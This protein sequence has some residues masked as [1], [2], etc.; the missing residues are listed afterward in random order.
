MYSQHTW[1]SGPK[2]FTGKSPSLK[3]CGG[4]GTGSYGTVTDEDLSRSITQDLHTRTSSEHSRRTFIQAPTQRIFKILLQGPLEE[5]FNRIFSQGPVPDHAPGPFQELLARDHA[6]ASGSI[7]LKILKS[8][9]YVRTRSFKAL[10]QDPLAGN[11][12]EN[13]TTTGRQPAQSKCTWTSHKSSFMRIYR[14]K[15]AP[16]ERNNHFAPS[17]RNRNAYRHLR[18]T[19]FRE[20]L[21]EKCRAPR[22]RCTVRVIL[23]SR[24]HFTREFAEKMPRPKIAPQTLCE[25]AQS[26]C[27]WTCQF[28][29]ILQGKCRKA[30]G[31]P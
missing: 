20:N 6:K 17:L 26:K 13:L 25:P 10:E 1:N 30:N 11:F 24:N 29:A 3:Q 16:Q 28:Y 12:K 22:S 21:Q 5:D 14:N 2:H 8:P 7:S 23:H 18:R 31:A 4:G 9:Q 15:A 19:I 27:T